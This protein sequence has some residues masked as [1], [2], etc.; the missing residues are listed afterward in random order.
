MKKDG[1]CNEKIYFYNA[2]NRGSI[3]SIGAHY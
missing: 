1:E 3:H 2:W